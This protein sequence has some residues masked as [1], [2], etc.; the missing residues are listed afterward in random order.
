MQHVP[1]PSQPPA[2]AASAA[3]GCAAASKGIELNSSAKIEPAPTNTLASALLQ[4]RCK[5]QSTV[6]H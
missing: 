2:Q 1:P 3:A 6:A 5:K 4:A